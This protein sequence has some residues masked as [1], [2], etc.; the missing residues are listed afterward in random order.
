MKAID[1]FARAAQCLQET[2]LEEK[3][4][5]SEAIVK[6]SKSGFTTRRS[7]MLENIVVGRPVQPK[8][9]SPADLPR[10]G[11]ASHK[12]RL[13]MIHAIAHIEFNAINLAWDAVYRFQDM[14]EDYYRDWIQVAGEETKHFCLLRA[15]LNKNNLDYG[16][17]DAHDGLWRM[18]EQT[19]FDVLARMAI[20]PRVLEAKGL[21]VT[22]AMIARF[23]DFKEQE[24]ADILRIIYREEIGHVKIGNR[25]FNYL[26][27][28]RNLDSHSVFISLLEQFKLQKFNAKLNREAR[29]EA[30]FK[31]EE[32]D[33]LERGY[34][35]QIQH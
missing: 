21:D 22:P 7:L 3:L 10:R 28:Q 29:L 30:G 24:V 12:A 32:L 14:P 35:P 1:L 23:E 26:C 9:V 15:Y 18:A 11:F 2:G 19:A 31:A 17:F 13:A 16:D 27:K 34:L 8:L 6:A 20:V 5:M 25:W 33:T 4:S